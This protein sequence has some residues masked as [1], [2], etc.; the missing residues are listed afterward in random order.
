MGAVGLLMVRPRFS[1]RS[2]S[3]AGSGRAASPWQAG[4][5]PGTLLSDGAEVK[6]LVRPVACRGCPG[7]AVPPLPSGEEG[8]GRLRSS[9]WPRGGD[10]HAVQPRVLPVL[11]DAL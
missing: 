9:P 5:V 10:R 11:E 6:P 4:P 8:F 2:G 1:G 7:G 3:G